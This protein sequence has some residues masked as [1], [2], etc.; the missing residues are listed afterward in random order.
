MYFLKCSLFLMFGVLLKDKA[1]LVPSL[2]GAGDTR[3]FQEFDEDHTIFN[4][5]SHSVYTKDFESF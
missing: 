2:R 3:M 1:P 4:I 5:S